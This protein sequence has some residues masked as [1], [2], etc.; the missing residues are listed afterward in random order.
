[1]NDGR[2]RRIRPFHELRTFVDEHRRTLAVDFVF[3]TVWALLLFALFLIGYA[4]LEMFY[5]GL[6]AVV[7][8]YSLVA[9]WREPT[10]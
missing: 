5:V 7:V 9:N 2:T 3:L 8:S 6:F 1:M 4:S 10:H